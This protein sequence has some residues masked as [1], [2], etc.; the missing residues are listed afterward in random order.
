ML[1]GTLGLNG[2]LS[3]GSRGDWATHNIEHAVSAYYDIP[4]AGGLAILL[5]NWMRHNLHVNPKR[6]VKMATK[7]FGV[8]VGTKSEEEVALEGIDA[9]ASFWQSIGAPKTLADF[10]IDDTHFEGIVEHTMF[11]GP[12]GNFSKLQQEDVMDILKASL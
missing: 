2:F 12:F 1:A 6:F 4:H 5:P 9:L 3:L 11:N 7:V 10:E 8:S